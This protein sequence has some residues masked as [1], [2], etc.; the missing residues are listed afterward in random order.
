MS[1]PVAFTSDHVVQAVCEVAIA[2]EQNPDS[3]DW[4]RVHL[5]YLA[6]VVRGE[7]RGEA[8]NEAERMLKGAQ[9]RLEKI[10]PKR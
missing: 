1:A 7:L 6:K 10:S 2:L 4:L 9:A 3:R 5:E 8:L